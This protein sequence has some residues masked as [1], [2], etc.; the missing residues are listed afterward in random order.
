VFEGS[1]IGSAGSLGNKASKSGSDEGRDVGELVILNYTWCYCCCIRKVVEARWFWRRDSKARRDED[2]VPLAPPPNSMLCKGPGSKFRDYRC[3]TDTCFAYPDL[4][5]SL[6]GDISGWTY[7][8]FD[9]VPNTSNTHLQTH[10]KPSKSLRPCR[11]RYASP[12]H[13]IPCPPT[14]SAVRALPRFWH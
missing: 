9:R 6:A 10:V 11:I 5:P 4:S 13:A 8:H 12:G 7:G 1:K 3:M 14:V 2:K